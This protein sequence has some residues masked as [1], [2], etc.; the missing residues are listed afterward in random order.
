MTISLEKIAIIIV[1]WNR[2]DDLL[3]LVASLYDAGYW[4]YDI[5]V[6]DNASSDGSVDA[7]RAR[8]PEVLL[9]QNAENLGGTGG[10]N[11]G[12]RYAIGR[13]YSF[14]WLLDNDALVF[15]NSLEPLVEAASSDPRI[16]LV[17]SKLLH[18]HDPFLINEAGAMIDPFTSRP[19]PRF[20]N[21][22]DRL[23]P[24]LLDVH[25]VAVCSVLVRLSAVKRVGLMDEAYFLM[26]D[27][28]EWGMRFRMKHY[29]VVVATES[30]VTHPGFSERFLTSNFIYYSTRNHFYFIARIYSGLQR[31]YLI[32]LLAGV[33]AYQA[34]R[35]RWIIGNRQTSMIREAAEVDFW[36]LQMGRSRRSLPELE[37]PEGK[38]SIEAYLSAGQSV[39]FSTRTSDRSVREAVS[40]LTAAGVRVVLYGDK[41]RRNIFSWFNGPSVWRSAGALGYFQ[42]LWG[43]WHYDCDVTVVHYA[44]F[45]R[46]PMQLSRQVIRINRKLEVISIS[47]AQP[48]KSFFC[49]L[50][51]LTRAS[52]AFAY[53][54]IRALILIITRK[55][56]ERVDQSKS[57]PITVDASKT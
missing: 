33:T 55:T 35:E 43:M 54:I 18:P 7:L 6:V 29:R 34:A 45:A 42:L 41:L 50:A 20:M 2:R 53:G 14:V 46:L 30:R 51:F 8:Y 15:P 16:A 49:E 5:I 56:L 26:W 1:N 21:E 3:A 32:A 22:H 19:R 52:F 23:L 44:E 39:A 25:Y 24:Q 48:I 57:M 10:F 38:H 31:S 9:I 37:E 40:R 13:D 28:M 11:A 12:M 47:H 17:G 27:D 4:N 36:S